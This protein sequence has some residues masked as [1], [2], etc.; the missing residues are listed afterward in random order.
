MKGWFASL[1]DLHQQCLGAGVAPHRCILIENAIDTSVYRRQLD[2]AESKRRLGFAPARILI[3]AVGR[4]AAEKNFRG[5]IKAMHQ[6]QARGLYA[7]LVIIGDGNQRGEL[8]S[9][10]GQLGLQGRVR[11]LGYRADMIELY[12]AMDIF[13][14]SSLREGLPNVFVGG[15]GH[16]GTDRSN[17]NCGRPPPG[18]S[19]A[20]WPAC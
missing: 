19:R 11:L 15:D 3:G 20:E 5:L 10:I 7:D 13:V 18:A 14:L 2:L 4:L 9:L 12:Q 17:A 1:K 8:E 6:L 16:G